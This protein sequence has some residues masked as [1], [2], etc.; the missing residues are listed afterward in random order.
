MLLSFLGTSTVL[1][2]LLFRLF[3]CRMSLM[4]NALLE[5]PRVALIMLQQLLW[6]SI[7]FVNIECAVTVYNSC[8]HR[9]CRHPADA[10]S[11]SQAAL[12]ANWSV[13][14]PQKIIFKQIKDYQDYQDNQNEKISI[15]QAWYE[16]LFHQVHQSHGLCPLL[17]S[18][19][20][21]QTFSVPM[22]AR[23]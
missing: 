9:V 10:Y 1:I 21:R 6:T 3:V 16:L 22:I 13:V 7:C 14:S 23:F 5:L 2:A 11:G 20:R 17:P 19:G 18:P 12:D 8:E 4:C 15:Q